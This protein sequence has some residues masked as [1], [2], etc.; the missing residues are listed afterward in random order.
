[1]AKRVLIAVYLD[2]VCLEAGKER[3]SYFR[4]AR[5]IISSLWLPLLFLNTISVEVF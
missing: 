4:V 5:Y 2:E 3:L 1:V